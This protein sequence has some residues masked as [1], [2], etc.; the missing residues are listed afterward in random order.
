MSTRESTARVLDLTSVSKHFSVTT[1]SGQRTVLRAVQQVDLQLEAGRTIGIVGES[2]C[3]KTTLG[4]MIVGLERPTSGQILVEGRD[5][6]AL[7]GAELR[8]ARRSVQI[9]F[10]DPLG[11]LNPR[12]AVEDLIGE[13]WRLHPIVKKADRTRAVISLLDQV[14]LASTHLR[15]YPTELSGGQQQRVCIARALALDPRIVVCDEPVSALDVSVQAQVLNVLR[16]IQNETGVAYVFVAHD[17]DVVRYIADDVAVMYLGRVVETGSTEQVYTKASH[18]Y[19]QAL[20]D[21]VPGR[22]H[23]RK[24]RLIEGEL[25]S[26]TDP[27][28]GCAFRTRCWRAQSRCADEVPDLTDR[29]DIGHDSACLYPSHDIYYGASV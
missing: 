21:A 20:L 8:D 7:R 23:D 18:P 28:S 4:R 17:L 5:L 13:P 14:G 15:R 29:L 11:S 2:G 19:T 25:P 10:Q 24:V 26:P 1:R 3:G 6:F 22:R 27:P 16:S 12:M 9:V